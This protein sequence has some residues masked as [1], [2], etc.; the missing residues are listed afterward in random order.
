MS[1]EKT[2]QSLS[3]LADGHATEQELDALL[4]AWNEDPALR[5]DWQ[6][7][8]LAGEALRT[9]DLS[10]PAQ[11]SEMLLANL[12][13]RIAAEPVQLRPRPAAR[14]LP[15]F[16][17][18]AGFVLLALL[19]PRL[20]LPGVMKAP[21][22][23]ADPSAQALVTVPGSRTFDASA[24]FVQTIVAP[25]QPGQVAESQASQH[26][27]RAAPPFPTSNA[28]SATNAASAAVIH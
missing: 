19:V 25:E 6:A 10:A 18:A 14:W 7:L 23:T 9:P 27:L 24:S 12:R 17:V 8:H 26:L 16:G 1:N 20:P 15:P 21:V 22:L 11:S 5:Q 4:R 28:A 3:N 13:E 2:L